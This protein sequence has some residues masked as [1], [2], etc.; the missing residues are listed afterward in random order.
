[1]N[2]NKNILLTLCLC[3]F[4]AVSASAD[5]DAKSLIPKRPLMLKMLEQKVNILKNIRT[6]LFFDDLLQASGVIES[7]FALL[8]FEA[9]VIEPRQTISQ[10]VAG[11]SIRVVTAN[12]LLFPPPFFFNQA[13]RIKEFAKSVAHKSPDIILLQE[14]WD[15]N[16]IHLIAR[17]FP[18]YWL[19]FNPAIPINFSGLV[20]LS[21]LRVDKAYARKYPPSLRFNFE[22]LLAFKGFMVTTVTAKERQIEI[23][24]SHLYSASP[25]QKIRP[26][27][28]QFMRL[29]HQAVKSEIPVIFGGDMNLLPDEVSKLLLPAIVADS[30]EQP[31]AG[32]RRRT[33]KLDW[34]FAYPG[35]GCDVTLDSSRLEWPVEFSDHSPV[36]GKINF[37]QTDKQ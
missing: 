20:T 2:N 33:K 22:E 19:V 31:T 27:P 28:S 1:M 3:L 24:N 34:L 36:Y 9:A 21:R 10:Q 15:I 37:I 26:N 6:L 18:D 14:V 16:S 12:L 23:I 32:L 25:R 30:C 4:M 7:I 11:D 5:A 13:E 29:Q 8:E 35:S 17:E